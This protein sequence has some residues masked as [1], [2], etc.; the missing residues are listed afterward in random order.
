MFPESVAIMPGVEDEE[1]SA[2]SYN[3]SLSKVLFEKQLHTMID[4]LDPA[5]KV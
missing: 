2:H 1:C 4:F 3:E 5:M